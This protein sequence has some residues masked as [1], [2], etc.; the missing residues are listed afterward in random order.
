MRRLSA[1][2]GRGQDGAVG[3]ARFRSS[4]AGDACPRATSSPFNAPALHLERAL[5]ILEFRECVNINIKQITAL[6]LLTSHCNIAF[7]SIM[8]VGPKPD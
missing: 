1:G 8:N 2:C 3:V 5:H 6:F 7:P 4:V